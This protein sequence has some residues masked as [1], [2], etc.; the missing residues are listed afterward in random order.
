MSEGMQKDAY[1]ALVHSLQ[2]TDKAIGDELVVTLTDR[3]NPAPVKV[4]P[5]NPPADPTPAD[6]AA[7]TEPVAAAA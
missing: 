7:P 6:S 2:K 4:E 3:A 1:I 5:A